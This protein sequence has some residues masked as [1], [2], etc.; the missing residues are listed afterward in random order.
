MISPEAL[1]KARDI[2]FD[3]D[4]DWTAD[5]R[6][7]GNREYQD[8]IN[9]IATALQAERDAA[10]P[11]LPDDL[12]GLVERLN[13]VYR[14]PITDGLGAVGAGEE[15]DNP[16]EFVRRFETPPIQKEAAATIQSLV[17]RIAELEAGLD[18]LVNAKALSGVRELVAGWNGENQPD[19]PYAERHP[20]RL[21]A[22]LPKTNCGAVYALDEAMQAARILLNKDR[23]P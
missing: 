12:A 11:K 16:N 19:G 17:A 9:A 7:Q 1:E 5:G 6:R 20:A 21:G 4:C 3:F 18:C 14:V 22:T 23:Q 13:G 2:A 15:P 8:A 10:A